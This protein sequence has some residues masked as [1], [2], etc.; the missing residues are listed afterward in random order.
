MRSGTSSTALKREGR[1]VLLTTHYLEEAEVLCDR[2]AIMDHGRILEMGTVD[3]L[4]APP[5]QGARGPVRRDSRASTTAEL[6]ALPGVI[7]V[8]HD[9]GDRAALH[10]RRPGDDRRRCSP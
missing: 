7:R 1:T 2:V 4:V 8:A 5:V 9:D 3:E 6:A 10:D